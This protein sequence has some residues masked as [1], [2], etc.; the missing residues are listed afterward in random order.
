MPDG[1]LP[2]KLTAASPG[3]RAG[4]FVADR[5]LAGPAAGRFSGRPLA[6]PPVA[7]YRPVDLAALA[8]LANPAR[9]TGAEA[10][11][12]AARAA[13]ALA[14]HAAPPD[15]APAPMP[16]DPAPA[17][18]E[19]A[20]ANLRALAAARDEAFARGQAEGRAE[21]RAEGLAEAQ[22]AMAAVQAEAAAAA[23]ALARALAR[24]AEPPETAVDMLAKTMQAAVARLA[25]Q[26][27]GQAIDAAPEPFARR[28]ARLAARVALQQQE[29][30]VHLHPADLAA[31]APLL[32]QACP[33]D[34]A[35]LAAARLVGDP[36]LARGDADLRAPGVRL[37]DLLDDGG[38]SA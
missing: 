16:R 5:R 36:A 24:L 35:A 27:A 10:A 33:G 6:A 7:R 4:A 3:P 20:A 1:S 38:A 21:G 8:T 18:E 15:P 17:A 14:P 12:A 19:T 29:L 32:A 26:R 37:A 31:V 30:T 28:V 13:A 25:S 9:G 2:P 34:L 11:A 23:R 22:A